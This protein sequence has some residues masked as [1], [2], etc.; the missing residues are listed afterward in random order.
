MFYQEQ[1]LAAMCTLISF[2]DCFEII[3]DPFKGK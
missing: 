2:A 3:F 1:I